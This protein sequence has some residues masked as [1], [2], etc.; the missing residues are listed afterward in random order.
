MRLAKV[1]SCIFHPVLMPLLGVLLIFNSGIY[2]AEVPF[3]FKRFVYA[4]VI[5]C[6]AVLPLT[7]LPALYLFKSVGRITLDEKQ[8]RIIPLF[9]TTVCFLMGY[10]ML[11]RYSPVKLIN[12]FLFSC[13]VVALVTLLISFFWKISLHMAG[14]GGLI[15]MIFVISLTYTVDMTVYLSVALLVAGIIASSRLALQKHSIWQVVAGF[16]VG[17]LFVSAT[18]FDFIRASIL[19]IIN[20]LV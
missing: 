2:V 19:E 4:M 7:L 3:E 8:E 6:T 17:F 18:M 20:K 14:I 12:L 5:L 10:F 11:A 16:L 9:F 13:V 1:V 15:A